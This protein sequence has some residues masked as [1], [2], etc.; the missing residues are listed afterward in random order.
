VLL[1]DEVACSCGSL[2]R[3]LIECLASLAE[4]QEILAPLFQV[5]QPSS[6]SDFA[7]GGWPQCNLGAAQEPQQ[8]R[9]LWSVF[10]PVLMA[11]DT[12]QYVAELLAHKKFA[13]VF[14]DRGGLQLLL[15]IPKQS[16]VSGGV[17]LCFYG[18]ASISSVMEQICLVRAAE[19]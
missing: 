12:L 16:Y 10:D 11:L 5:T 4:Y 18:L 19:N 14:V 2:G 17:A 7:P 8:V 13:S 6:G 1:G 3:Y 15:E 9:A